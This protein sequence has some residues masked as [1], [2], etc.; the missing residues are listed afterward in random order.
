[1]ISLKLNPVEKRL[2]AAKRMV[3]LMLRQNE[4]LRLPAAGQ[5]LQAISGVAWI[6]VNGRDIFLASG[7]RFRLPSRGDTALISALGRQSLILEV[8]GAPW[9]A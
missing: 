2:S 7:E 9:G 6:T 3:R 1:M 8:F 5:E 4:V